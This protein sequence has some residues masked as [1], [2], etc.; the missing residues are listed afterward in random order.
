MNPSESGNRHETGVIFKATTPPSPFDAL[1]GPSVIRSVSTHLLA[2]QTRPDGVVHEIYHE[3]PSRDGHK[4]AIFY[5]TEN[6]VAG[7]S[8]TQVS[9]SILYSM[10]P[11]TEPQRFIAGVIKSFNT[12]PPSQFEQVFTGSFGG[13]I[14]I[15]NSRAA[16]Y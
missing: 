6:P 16:G 5:I 12:L 8:T 14:L 3:I 2:S 7:S 13:E 9:Q 11:N 4:G 15:K 10:V 1:K